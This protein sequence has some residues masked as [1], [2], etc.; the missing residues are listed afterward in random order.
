VADAVIAAR[1]RLGQHHLDQGAREPGLRCG[2]GLLPAQ[3]SS[4]PGL[5]TYLLPAD[6][7]PLQRACGCA[8]VLGGQAEQEVAGTPVAVAVA[9]GLGEGGGDRV[10]GGAGEGEEPGGPGVDAGGVLSCRADGG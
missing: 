10:A 6:A 5:L 7:Q 9:P 1:R 3:G 8:L 4:L 2:P